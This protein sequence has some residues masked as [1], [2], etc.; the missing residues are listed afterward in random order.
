LRICRGT[1]G[2]PSIAAISAF[3]YLL[4]GRAILSETQTTL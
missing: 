1:F 2:W 3:R 4:V